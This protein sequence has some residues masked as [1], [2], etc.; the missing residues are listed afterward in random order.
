[1]RDH[2][3]SQLDDGFWLA[4]ERTTLY[5]HPCLTP[6]F[7]M[8]VVYIR[9]PDKI[10]H[11]SI[12]RYK[13]AIS[14][15]FN[16][17]S[18]RVASNNSVTTTKLYTNVNIHCSVYYDRYQE[19]YR[20]TSHGCHRRL[21]EECVSTEC[22]CFDIGDQDE[23][24]DLSVSGGPGASPTR[25]GRSNDGTLPRGAADAR[26]HHPARGRRRVGGATEGAHRQVRQTGRE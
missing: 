21:T 24:E 1:M 13:A 22:W 7:G 2:D 6:R 12:T 8:F 15:T 9:L 20:Y 23:G 17:L 11:L 19:L 14:I 5:T 25:G 16:V 26:S 4:I 10:H 3:T 18:L